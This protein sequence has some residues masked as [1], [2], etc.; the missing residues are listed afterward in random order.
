MTL[1]VIRLQIEVL[2]YSRLK[3]QFTPDQE[4]FYRFLLAR[5]QELIEREIPSSGTTASSDDDEITTK[6]GPSGAMAAAIDGAPA[7]HEEGTST[8]G[9]ARELQAGSTIPLELTTFAAG[10]GAK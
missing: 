10:S 5:E 3:G 7:N 8:T 9:P 6:V 4:R 2:E 1:A